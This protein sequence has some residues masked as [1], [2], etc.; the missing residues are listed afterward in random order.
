MKLLFPLTS[1]FLGVL[2]SA[3]KEPVC[4]PTELDTYDFI[5]VGGGTAGSA[6]AAELAR[7]LPDNTVL[8]LDQGKDFSDQAIVMDN[9]QFANIQVCEKGIQF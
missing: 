2:A 7:S 8:L 6:A 5:V 1:C 9:D 4:H 3:A